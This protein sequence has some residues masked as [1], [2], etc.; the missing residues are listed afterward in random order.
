MVPG[1]SPGGPTIATV[2]KIGRR[3]SLGCCWAPRAR[4]GSIPGGGTTMIIKS[5][6]HR[7]FLLVTIC[8]QAIFQALINEIHSSQNE[9]FSFLRGSLSIKRF[10]SL[11]LIASLVRSPSL[12]LRRSQRYENSSTYFCRCFLYE[13]SHTLCLVQQPTACL[14][15]FFPGM[16][17]K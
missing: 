12:I 10:P 4:P 9:S 1:S 8:K 15:M 7:N 3:D 11:D 14:L 16:Y 17:E 13:T 6:I 2:P 5:L